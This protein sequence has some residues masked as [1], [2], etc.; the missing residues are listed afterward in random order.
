METKEEI[1]AAKGVK[2]TPNRL[3]VLDALSKYGSP[4]SVA[5]LEDQLQTVDRSSVFRVLTLFAEHGLVHAIEDGSG[6]VKYEL[7]HGQHECT[8]ADMHVHFYCDNCHRTICLES[9]PIPE[10]TLPE[11]FEARTANYIIKGLCDKCKK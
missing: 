5:E 7:C 10:V 1:L 2:A 11:G 6:A 9:Q 3:L 8:P 4:V